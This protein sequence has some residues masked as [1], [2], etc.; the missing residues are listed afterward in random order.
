M[1]LTESPDLLRAVCSAA[2]TRLCCLLQQRM[3]AAPHGAGL[4]GLS[5]PSFRSAAG[6]G[7]DVSEMAGVTGNSDSATASNMSQPNSPL[8]V[9]AS[10][11]AVQSL[12]CALAA[13]PQSPLPTL[14]LDAMLH[15]S[16]QV[17]LSGTTH[18]NLVPLTSISS[19]VRGNEIP[20]L[21]LCCILTCV[22]LAAAQHGPGPSSDVDS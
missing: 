17:G 5:T 10:V 1:T 7:A 12:C 14:L 4:T 16:S 8:C 9:D 2:V 3:A 19:V 20:V 18:I 13:A 21:I 6:A 15:R 22:G 11:D